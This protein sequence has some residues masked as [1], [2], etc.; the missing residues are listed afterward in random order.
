MLGPPL[1]HA[2]TI[3]M[4]HSDGASIAAI[5]ADGVQDHR[6]RAIAD[7]PVFREVCDGLDDG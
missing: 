5:Y 4:L 2:P 7:R 6:A 3:V 1:A